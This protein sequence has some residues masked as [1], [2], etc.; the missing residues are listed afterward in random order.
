MCRNGIEMLRQL[1]KKVEDTIMKL[2]EHNN[3]EKV[4]GQT[5]QF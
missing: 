5:I 4:F 1:R 2:I 3:Q